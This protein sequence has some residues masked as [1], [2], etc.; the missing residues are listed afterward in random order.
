MAE[1]D[2]VQVIRSLWFVLMATCYIVGLR[3]TPQAEAMTVVQL[4]FYAVGFAW[5]FMNA[6]FPSVQPV[7]AK[8][9]HRL[10]P[11]SALGLLP[12]FFSAD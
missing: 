3:W 6:E 2:G 8:N 12:L 7:D 1:V 5:H 10:P 11:A 9:S 4:S